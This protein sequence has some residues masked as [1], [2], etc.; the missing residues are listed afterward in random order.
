MKNQVLIKRYTQG[1]VNALKGDAEFLRVMEE[2]EAFAGIVRSNKDLRLALV[3]P[4]L[5]IRKRASI[6]GD[7]LGLAA[8]HEKTKKFLDLLVEHGRLDLLE[9]IMAVLPEAWNEKLGVMTFTAVSAVPMTGVQKDRL[10]AALELLEKKPVTLVIRIDPGI[11]G[12]LTVKKSNIVYDASV[13][14]DL[15][16]IM[17]KIQEG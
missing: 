3:N 11:I 16:T 15:L 5:N 17:E 1:L 4:F 13:E 2:L 9:D 12:G 7:I 8:C 6:V 14:G 10:R